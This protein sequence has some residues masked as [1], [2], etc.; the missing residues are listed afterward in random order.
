MRF[1]EA[2]AGNQVVKGGKS[3][4]RHCTEAVL[5]KKEAE[6]NIPTGKKT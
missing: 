2:L 3:K 1:G 5:S 6:E 4:G